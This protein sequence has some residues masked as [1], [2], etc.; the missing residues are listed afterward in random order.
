MVHQCLVVSTPGSPSANRLDARRPTFGGKA[1][2]LHVLR[3]CLVTSLLK[4][5]CWPL[6]L[7]SHAIRGHWLLISL[8]GLACAVVTFFVL[9]FWVFLPQY[10]ATALLQLAP[11]NPKFL[12][13]VADD[14]QIAG[15]FVFFA[16]TK[17]L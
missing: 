12:T 16:K 14:Q 2:G 5:I 10:K 1:D 15:E 7:V 3:R 11:S 8:T 9:L 4:S 17:R 13:T 6:I